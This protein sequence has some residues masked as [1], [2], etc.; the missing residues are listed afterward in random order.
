MNIVITGCFNE[1]AIGH[2][3]R[4]EVK[5]MIERRG[6]KVRSEVTN[7]TDYLCI[8]TA[9]SG[10]PPGPAKLRQ[11][12]DLGVKVVTLSELLDVLNAA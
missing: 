6:H 10:R 4:T 9:V 3:G 11:A 1:Q 12:R 7:T 5:N 8:G 2:Y